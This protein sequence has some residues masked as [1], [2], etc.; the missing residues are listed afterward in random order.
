MPTAIAGRPTNVINSLWL[1]ITG[2]CQLTCTHCYASSGPTGDH[3]SMTVADWQ[4]VLN[5][6]AALRVGRVTI[7]GGEPTLH[8]E[9]GGLIDY[10]VG[11]G[12]A[13][14]VYSNLVRVPDRLWPALTQAGVSLATSYYSSDP[15]AHDR[16]TG[17]AR[18][19]SRTRATIV[20][21]LR[22]GIPLR[23]GLIGDSDSTLDRAH[24]ELLA[25]GVGSITRD[26]IRPVGRADHGES[27]HGESGTCGRCGHGRAAIRADG[28]VTPCVFTRH[29]ITGN[30]RVGRLAE[31]LAGTAWASQVARLDALRSAATG[32][33]PDDTE[34]GTCNPFTRPACQ[35]DYPDSD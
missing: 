35:P 12:L 26:G 3:G 27:D 11:L 31:T 21:M 7:I 8:P 14:E 24:A 28:T 23:V 9:L 17:Q 18:S 16:M 15:A 29:A 6:A 25:L 30:V 5:E 1:E 33:S 10:A 34:E 20:E 22:R 32:C 19:H 4:R 13:V 2:R